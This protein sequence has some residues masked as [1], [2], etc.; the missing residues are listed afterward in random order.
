ME[1][2]APT[3]PE[4]NQEGDGAAEHQLKCS[5]LASS[6]VVQGGKPQPLPTHGLGNMSSV[7]WG[8]SVLEIIR[9]MAL[10][11]SPL[12]LIAMIF[13]PTLT[14]SLQYRFLQS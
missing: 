8:S 7:A 4:S 3:E 1:P 9:V 14:T 6:Q 2:R 13:P 5:S 11:R 10:I 12:L